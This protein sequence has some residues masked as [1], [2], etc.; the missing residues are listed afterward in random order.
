MLSDLPRI[1]MLQELRFRPLFDTMR[2]KLRHLSW[3]IFRSAL[4]H[5]FL[6]TMCWMRSAHW[7]RR[8][9]SVQDKDVRHVE[10]ELFLQS[11]EVGFVDGARYLAGAPSVDRTVD[12]LLE[13]GLEALQ[14]IAA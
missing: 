4:S 2:G 13:S 7:V 8:T 9:Y 12:A 10:S 3:S 5:S 14:L 6:N 1:I 11:H